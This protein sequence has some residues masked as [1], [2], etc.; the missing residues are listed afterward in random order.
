M[1]KANV[2]RHTQ[3]L[4]SISNWKITLLV[5]FCTGT[6][7]S[8]AMP[9]AVSVMENSCLEVTRSGVRVIDWGGGRLPGGPEGCDGGGSGVEAP[10]AVVLV[11]GEVGG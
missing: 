6:K 5:F 2:R 11:V 7:T 3:V 1:F 4:K 10:S 9:V 8:V